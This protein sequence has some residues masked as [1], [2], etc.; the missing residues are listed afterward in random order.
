MKKSVRLHL[1]GSLHSM[2]FRLFIK[3]NADKLGVRG[4]FRNLEDGKVE[5]FLEGDG[6]LVDQ[7]TQICKTGPKHAIIR[8]CEIKE[9]RF[10]DFKDFRFINF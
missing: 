3:E 7:M 8:G 1:T 6:P 4:F 2:F 9:E 10:Q 5:I